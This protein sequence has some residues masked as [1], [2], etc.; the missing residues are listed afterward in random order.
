MRDEEGRRVNSINRILGEE[1]SNLPPLPDS[2]VKVQAICADP[3]SAV[4][5]LAEVV[6]RDPLL[7]ANLLRVANSPFYGYAGRIHNV[8]HAVSLFGMATVLGFA[9][10]SAVRSGFAIDLSP[11]GIS[12]GRFGAMAQKRS[13]L[14]MHWYRHAPRQAREILVP[15]AFLESIGMVVVAKAVARAGEG[16]AFHRRLAAGEACDRVELDAVGSTAGTVSARMLA[17]WN[18]DPLMT[19]AIWVGEGMAGDNA[20]ELQGL[21][22]ALR[23]VRTCVRYD[24]AV[25][26]Y[27]AQQAWELLRAAGLE[28]ESF[29]EALQSLG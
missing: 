4:K 5:D 28:E 11:Y 20:A 23:V 9:V 29:G 27:S 7:T 25:T 12:P 21:G 13:S 10:A 1:L 19:Q 17:N 2:V 24:G 3:D 8:A 26:E 6:E 22:A 14:A 18:L 15:A 16:D